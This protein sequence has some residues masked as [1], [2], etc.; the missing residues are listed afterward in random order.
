MSCASGSRTFARRIPSTS[1]KATPEAR[2][3]L[4]RWR[5]LASTP[6][7]WPKSWRHGASQLSPL[8]ASSHHAHSP[9]RC[10]AGSHPFERRQQAVL[11]DGASGWTRKQWIVQSPHMRPQDIRLWNWMA[12]ATGAK[13]VALLGLSFGSDGNRSDGV[14]TCGTRRLATE[15]VLEASEDNRLIQ[16]HWDIIQNYKPKPDVALLFDQ[17][18]SLLTFRHERRRRCRPRNPSVAITRHSGS[19][20]IG[21]TLS[22]RKPSSSIQS[23]HR[24]LAPHG[25]AGNMCAIATVRRGRGNAAAGNRI[26]HV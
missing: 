15:R 21:W 5:S 20:T 14:W 6:G 26:R 8:V 13:G 22:S 4:N 10:A 23:H 3:W 24:A 7:G 16:A 11:D 1:L 12:V 19:A 25:K 18:N 2:S 17:D 9:G